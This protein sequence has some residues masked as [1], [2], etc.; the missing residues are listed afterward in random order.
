M[1]AQSAPAGANL[2]ATATG[3]SVALG[4]YTSTHGTTGTVAGGSLALGV[5]VFSAVAQGTAAAPPY[6]GTTAEATASGGLT[7][8]SYADHGS[9]S[10]PYGPAPVSESF[11]MAVATSLGSDSFATHDQF[12]SLGVHTF[13][14]LG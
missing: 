6:A 5:A 14:G 2:I 13:I 3:A 11:S 8:T 1:S 7:S 4:N 12:S 9:I 10:Y